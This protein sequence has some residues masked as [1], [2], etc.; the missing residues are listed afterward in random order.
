MGIVTGQGSSLQIGQETAWGTK[1][2]PTTAINFL[3]ES[4]KLVV[5]RKEEDTLVGGVTSRAQDIMKRSVEGDFGLIMKP[6]NTGLLFAMALGVEASPVESPT[7]VYEHSFTPIH[8]GISESLP[9]FSAIVDRHVA[10]KAYTGLKVGSLKLEAKAGDYLRATVSCKGKDEEA[11]TKNAS[12]KIPSAKAYRFAGG[13]CTFDSIEFGDV[14]G[15]TVDYSNELDEGEQ[16]L[17]SGYNGT[18]NEPQ[19]R[20]ITISIETAYNSASE[21]VREGKFK[22]EA[23]VAVKLRFVS[24]DEIVIGTKHAIEIELPL[25][26]ITECSPAVSGKEKLKL[27]IAGT[28]LES[29]T[30]EAI[31]ITLIDDKNAKY[32]V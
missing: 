6:G 8:A 31:I 32:G 14:T 17:A 4:L 11:G 28:A 9:S 12:L 15:V 2:A 16:T 27:S 3:N 22:T 10:V 1:I 26:A 19:A 29:D 25:V 23:T 5:E 7:G 21:T 30:A 20:K 13:S 24:P 18:E